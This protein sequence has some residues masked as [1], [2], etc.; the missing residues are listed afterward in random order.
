MHY[1]NRYNDVPKPYEKE[2]LKT[3]CIE[4]AKKIFHPRFLPLFQLCNPDHI[5]M[6]DLQSMPNS[7]KP[8]ETN[9]VTLLGDAI[10]VMT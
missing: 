5:N 2:E 8:W 10:H 4:R 6:K 3:F 1:D 7:I 9:R